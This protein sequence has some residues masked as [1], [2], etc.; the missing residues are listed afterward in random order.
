LTI[1][2]VSLQAILVTF[3]ELS[4]E[5]HPLGNCDYDNV[6]LYDGSD[7]DS[8]L[9]AFVCTVAQLTIRSSG[10]SLAVV[11]K[12]DHSVNIGRFSLS[13]TFVRQGR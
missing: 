1:V 8:P 2:A 11:F 6:A 5:R 3:D 13:W 10:S 12:S 4:L 7:L 9:L